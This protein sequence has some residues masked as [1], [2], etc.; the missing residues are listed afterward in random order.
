M[1]CGLLAFALFFTACEPINTAKEV[2]KKSA[3]GLSAENSNSSSNLSLGDT[4]VGDDSAKFNNLNRALRSQHLNNIRSIFASLYIMIDE[5]KCLIGQ[6][7]NINSAGEIQDSAFDKAFD[8][9]AAA[10]EQCM[11]SGTTRT[12][13][14]AADLEKFE[15]YLKEALGHKILPACTEDNQCAR[16]PNG[17]YFSAGLGGIFSKTIQGMESQIIDEKL[18]TLMIDLADEDSA[19]YTDFMWATASLPDPVPVPRCVSNVCKGVNP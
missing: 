9:I 2:E 7:L 5:E 18:R 13:I 17:G 16:I 19:D 15:T 1:R 14:K 12:K 4:A 11:G 8:D 6:T 10:I 3:A